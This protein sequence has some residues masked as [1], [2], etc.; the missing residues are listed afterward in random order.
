VGVDLIVVLTSQWPNEDPFPSLKKFEK[1][2]NGEIL[3]KC[4]NTYCLCLDDNP[5]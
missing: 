4:G 5:I 3:D 1:E 2:G